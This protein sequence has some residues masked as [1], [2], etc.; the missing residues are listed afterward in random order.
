MPQFP[1]KQEV[2]AKKEETL[3][4]ATSNV[5]A[6]KPAPRLVEQKYLIIVNP[7]KGSYHPL[8]KELR[9]DTGKIESQFKMIDGQSTTAIIR[10]LSTVQERLFATDL[11]NKNPNDPN[12][13]EA[14]TMYWADFS[15][16]VKEKK[17]LTL[18]ASYRIET[19]MVDGELREV[20][21]PVNLFQYIKATFAKQ[22]SRV[23]F[24]EEDVANSYLF[25]FIMN[26][27]SEV[28]KA[29]THLFKIRNRAGLYYN[30]LIAAYNEGLPNEK[31]EYLVEL[32]KEPKENFASAT[33]EDKLIFL[34]TKKNSDPETFISAFNDKNLEAKALLYQAA[35]AGIITI[36]G[37]T[38]FYIDE[39]MGV[40][41]EAINFI[42]DATK[43]GYV[44]KIKA[45]LQKK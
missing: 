10:G 26:D 18:D 31:I 33:I 37:N 5:A 30:E 16:E 45:G 32:L 25:D 11:I 40:E 9:E 6:A 43:S 3:A 42:Q 4:P 28:K 17:G 15:V 19:R 44:S 20:E 22:S 39:N 12:F 14:M 24:R 2:V 21:V 35:R 38:Y 27:L 23:A 36:E 41:A 1:N 8:P 29:E 13:D 34:E 7:R